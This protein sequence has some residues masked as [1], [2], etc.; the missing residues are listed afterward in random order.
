MK[1]TTVQF[2]VLTDPA[3]KG[4]PK[5]ARRGKHVVA[6]TPAKTL[7]KEQEIAEAAK[8]EMG[9][10]VPFQNECE[11]VFSFFLPIPKSISIKNKKKMNDGNIYH[12]KK[13]DLDNLSKLVLDAMNGIVYKDDSQVWSIC[14][15]KWYSDQPRIEV[16]VHHHEKEM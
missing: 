14:M 7:S 6:Y 2:V 5:F 15:N 3:G 1:I 11:C 4:R 13:P 12:T 10:R 9:D 16:T 8:Q